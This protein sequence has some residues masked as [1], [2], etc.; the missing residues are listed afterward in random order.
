M[1]TRR[2]Q[3]W[4]LVQGQRRLPKQLPDR[5]S[6]R[7]QRVLQTLSPLR[8]LPNTILSELKTLP[9]A[10]VGHSTQNPNQLTAVRAR[11]A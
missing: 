5:E 7:Q 3:K 10:N 2:P 9:L 4:M 6:F 11:I 8:M 1:S